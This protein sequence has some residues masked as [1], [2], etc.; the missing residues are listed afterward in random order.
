[1]INGLQLLELEDHQ[2]REVSRQLMQEVHLEKRAASMPSM[3]S[4]GVE[5]LSDTLR[6]SPARCWRP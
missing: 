3:S 1:M 6:A 5:R 2:V 4:V